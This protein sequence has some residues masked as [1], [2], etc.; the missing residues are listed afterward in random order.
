MIGS[1]SGRVPIKN[2][3]SKELWFQGFKMGACKEGSRVSSWETLSAERHDCI[4][5]HEQKSGRGTI[6]F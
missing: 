5:D 6:F 4:L 1:Q 2:F 3:K